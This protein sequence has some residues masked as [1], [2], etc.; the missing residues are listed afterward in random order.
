MHIT[1]SLDGVTKETYEAVRHR[2]NFET[3][4]ANLHRFHAYTRERGTNFGI[5]CCLLRQNWHELADVIL[6]AERLDC[7]LSINMVTGPSNCSLFT[8]P[9]REL[10]RVISEIEHDVNAIAPQLARHRTAWE[11]TA[12]HL[13]AAAEPHQARRIETIIAFDLLSDTPLARAK[14]LTAEGKFDEAVS[15]LR[16]MKRGHADY[17]FALS[18]AG[19]VRARQGDTEGALTDLKEALEISRK[20]PQAYL[21]LARVQFRQGHLNAALE[22]ARL[23]K[24]RAVSEE[25]IE[26][27]VLAMLGLI[28]TRQGRFRDAYRM[29][30]RIAALPPASHEGV[31]LPGT[32]AEAIKALA[33]LQDGPTAIGNR[34]LAYYSH[35]LYRTATVKHERRVRRQSAETLR[36][37]GPSLRGAS[38]RSAIARLVPNPADANIRS[39][40]RVAGVHNRARV[41]SLPEGQNA[42]RVAIEEAGNGVAYDIQLNYGR[43]AFEKAR[44]YRIEFRVRADQPR[45]A[46]FGIARTFAPWSNLGCYRILEAGP[47]WQD[48]SLDFVPS[49][50][51]QNGRLHFDLGESGTSFE[52]DAV[53]VQITSQG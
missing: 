40:L 21:G 10:N 25:R 3:V 30:A 5:S 19:S 24:E 4:I 50:D 6:L 32:P 16:Q 22:N 44:S 45:T 18:L 38:A 37:P 42:V 48:V 15:N 17:Y 51:D 33:E 14:R 11:E 26:T 23:A 12:K 52:V 2:A 20:L 35:L 28:L 27:E 47:A 29:Y 36:A 41:V 7:E 13:R 39:S 9:A 31:V 49:E 1:V 46:G 8:L 34:V 43:F 53:M